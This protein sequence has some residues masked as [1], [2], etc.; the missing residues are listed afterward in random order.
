MR[1]IVFS[2][3]KGGSGKTTHS[4]HFAVALEAMGQGPV[5]T[6]DLDPQ[7]SF[8]D[9]W[10]DRGE[11]T[12]A[13]TTV[14]N[15]TQL[16]DKQEKLA[17]AGFR[18]CVI[19]TPPQDHEINRTAIRLA[20][21]VVIPAKH[22]PHDIRAA[23]ST[24]EMCEKEHKRFFFLLNETNGKAVSLSATRRLAAMGPVIP[25]AVPKLNGYWESM[26]DGRTFQEISKGTG[27]IVIDSVATFLISQFEKTIRQEKAHA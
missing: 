6:M 2:C 1:T 20:D 7:G 3:L 23:E 8:S 9:W 5:V 11:R 4:A 13:F 22:S 19:D 12:P 10:N 21:L 25:H 15:M 24:V 17:A 14:K 27:A 18:W 16:A 26:I